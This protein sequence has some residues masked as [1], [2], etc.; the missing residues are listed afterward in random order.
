MWYS[1]CPSIYPFSQ[2]IAF[3]YNNCGI[4]LEYIKILDLKINTKKTFGNKY[5]RYYNKKFS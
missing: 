2:S 5:K 1:G 4:V 3:M